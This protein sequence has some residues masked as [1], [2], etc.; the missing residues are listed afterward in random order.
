MRG[1]VSAGHELTARAGAEMLRAGGNAFDAA[2]SAAFA[3]F[4][5]EPVLTSM[6]G[7][8]FLTA[9][10]SGGGTTLYDFFTDVPGLGRGGGREGVEFKSVDVEFSGC[11][12]EFHVGE[13][14]A[15]VPGNIAGLSEVFERHC[16][17][18]LE[19]ILAP[20]IGYARDGVP[21]TERQAYFVG[22]LAPIL[23]LDKEAR[24]IYA[25]SGALI[26]A[27]EVLYNRSLAATLEELKESG[28]MSFYMGAVAGKV[29]E[30]FSEKGFITEADLSGYRVEK[31]E[32]LAVSY[33]GRTVYT[34]PPPSS[35]GSLIAFSLKL[36][37]GFDIAAMGHNSSAYLKLLAAVKRV[38]NEARRESFD[39]LIYEADM[40]DDFL[41][42]VNVRRYRARVGGGMAA[43][44][45]G[46][47]ASHGNTTHISTV[48]VEGNAA[49]I[50][51]STGSGCGVMIPGTG[52]MM[53]NMLGE[54]DLNPLG[55]HMQSPATR[56]SSMMAPTIVMKGERPEVVLGSGGSNRIRSAILQVILNIVD[57]QL[58]VFEAVNA[59][60]VYYDRGTLH[61]EH[62]VPGSVLDSVERAIPDLKRWSVKDVFFGG[63]HT[64][65]LA[66]GGPA[67]GGD[68]RRGGAYIVV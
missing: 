67:G 13:G 54:E 19:T 34:N 33:R 30:G 25:P 57:F 12:Q 66:P 28:L 24:D 51:T 38:T 49:S 40:A 63:A 3:S 37:E 32:P 65:V 53:N 44:G 11:T 41:S 60:R 1:V 15:A 27:G 10:T 48:D 14:A 26:K 9:H 42:D 18:P 16:T 23:M 36:L 21:V 31:R 17:L 50:T 62:G 35:G 8:G 68:Q 20:A 58:P 2:V 7:G 56:M 61:V 64:A 59:P 46:P 6:A 55:F 39:H 22:I 4:V 29:L 45:A 47:D 43:S 52:V 5:T